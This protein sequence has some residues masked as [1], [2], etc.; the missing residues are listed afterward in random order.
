MNDIK[1]ENLF[2]N[3]APPEGGVQVLKEKLKKLER[4]RGFFST[5]KLK[6]VS[7]FAM[8]VLIALGISPLFL[9]PEKN[10]FTDLVSKSDNQIFIKYGY[11][12]NNNEA[13]S[14]PAGSRS[15]IATMRIETVNKNVKF[16]LI[17]SIT[18]ENLEEI[19]EESDST[20]ST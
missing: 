20:S 13:V 16:Y 7:A 11:Q 4:K 10:L 12:N 14:I 17:E 6:L 15:Q 2:N 5:P 9:K 8:V 19:P 3:I 18:N 1:F